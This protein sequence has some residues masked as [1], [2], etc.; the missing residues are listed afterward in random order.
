MAA[1]VKVTSRQLSTLLLLLTDTAAV[2]HAGL[3]C[4]SHLI[5]N[6]SDAAAEVLSGFARA[7]EPASQQ[8]RSAV[9]AAAARFST[10]NWT[11]VHDLALAHLAGRGADAHN[12]PTVVHAV[13]YAAGNTAVHH[14]KR[15]FA[16]VQRV[17]FMHKDCIPDEVQSLWGHMPINT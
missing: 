5:V 4:I 15:A 6:T 14:D 7:A 16:L 11:F 3:Q 12:W 9:F 1:F 2:R 10:L 8:E 17:L 13:A